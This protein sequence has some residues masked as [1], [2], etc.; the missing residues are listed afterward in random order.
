MCATGRRAGLRLRGPIHGTVPESAP[1]SA[2]IPKAHSA[3]KTFNMFAKA[4][5]LGANKVFSNKFPQ[6]SVTTVT[7]VTTVQTQA[8]C[9]R[10]ERSASR[11][12]AA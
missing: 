5:Y 4:K 2:M 3:I 8:K 7:T 11:S 9:L 10:L 6:F 1:S 12:D